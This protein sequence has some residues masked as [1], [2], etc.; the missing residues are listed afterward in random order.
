MAAGIVTVL[1]ALADPTR[2][3]IVTIIESGTD[4]CACEIEAVLRL[5]QS[6]ASRHLKKLVDAGVLDAERRG[7]WI[8]YRLGVGQDLTRSILA[9]LRRDEHDRHT[10]AA[11]TTALAAY[12]QSPYRCA[13][14]REWRTVYWGSP[15]ET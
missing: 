13:T 3:R 11:D 5:N 8:H 15:L 6:N 14:I 12:R 2:L 7:Q 4:L 10:Y 9:E 1:K